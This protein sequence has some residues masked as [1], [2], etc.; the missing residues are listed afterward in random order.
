M[1]EP[2]A[3]RSKPSTPGA[4]TPKENP[5]LYVVVVSV[6]SLLLLTAPSAHLSSDKR[7]QSPAGDSSN[8]YGSTSN[9]KVDNPLAGLVPRKVTTAQAKKIM[10]GLA[11]DGVAGS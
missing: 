2:P 6:A 5:Y 10:V 1:S 8:G 3:K 7:A 9:G 4:S 11:R